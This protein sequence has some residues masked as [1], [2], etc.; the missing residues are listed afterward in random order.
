M[1]QQPLTQPRPAH[2]LAPLSPPLLSSLP[3]FAQTMHDLFF[4]CQLFSIFSASAALY[5][6]QWGS[7]ADFWSMLTNQLM[8]MTGTAASSTGERDYKEKHSGSKGREQ[9]LLSRLKS[10]LSLLRS[11][12]TPA[13]LDL[14]AV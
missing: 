5:A 6:S 13:M 2:L 7:P 12:T 8:D 14:S 9:E 3:R 10:F 4:F 1:S 11:A